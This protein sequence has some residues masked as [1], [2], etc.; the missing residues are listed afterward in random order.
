MLGYT[1]GA[2]CIVVVLATFFGLGFWPKALANATGIKVSPIYT[3]GEVA[4]VIDHGVY[5]TVVHEPV[6]DGL[7]TKRSE[8]FV[9]IDWVPTEGNPLPEV[10]EEELDVDGNQ[11]ADLRIRIHPADGDC[12][13][14]P[15][16]GWVLETEKMIAA[17]QERIV[18]IRLRNPGQRQ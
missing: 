5:R 15:I 2:L 7:F 8:G 13:L 6:F 4:R 14:M 17:D 12:R 11:T 3:G 10:I 1:W 9:Q 16:A 18:R